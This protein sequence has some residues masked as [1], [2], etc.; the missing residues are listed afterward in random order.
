VEEEGC[1]FCDIDKSIVVAGWEDVEV[2]QME[3]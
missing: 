2:S 3:E 1:V